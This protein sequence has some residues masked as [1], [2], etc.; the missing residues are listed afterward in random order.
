MISV[1]AV[2][3]LRM[4]EFA[5][6]PEIVE[7]LRDHRCGRKI[8]VFEGQDVTPNEDKVVLKPA[9]RI[10]LLQ[11][12]VCTTTEILSLSADRRVVTEVS[13]TT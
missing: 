3:V 6:N 8:D 7:L 12:L 13:V 10:P 2:C 11:S 4:C 1:Q 5:P 9:G